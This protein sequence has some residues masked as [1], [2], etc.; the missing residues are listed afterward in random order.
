MS[1][2]SKYVLLTGAR[3]IGKSSLVKA[4]LNKFCR[5]GLRAGAPSH[6]KCS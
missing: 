1:E 5:Y 3:G 4:V 6:A 2:L